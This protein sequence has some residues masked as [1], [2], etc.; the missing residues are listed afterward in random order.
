MATITGGG[1]GSGLDVN[2]IVEKLMEIERKPLATFDAKQNTYQTKLS[3]FSIVKGNLA[4]LQTAAT[5]LATASTFTSKSAT[6]SDA[7]VLS[8]SAS[9]DVAAGSYSISVTQLAKF[10][11]VRSNTDYAATSDTFNTGTLAIS[12]GGGAAVNV[13][14]DGSNNT[15]AGIR[16]AI[17]D[18]VAGV[19]ATI[20]NDGT[21][22]RLILT[23]A[24]SGSA[25][26]INVA[27]TDDG[28][29][30]SNALS[31]L[32]T[33]SLVDVQ[34]AE[35]ALFTINGLAVSRSSNTVTDVV[36]GLTLSLTKGTL[37]SPGTAT[38]TVARNTAVVTSAVE[39]FVKAYNTAVD[40]L[41]S[42]SAYNSATK[43]GGPLNA[44]GTARSIR[45]DLSA[46]TFANVSGVAGS[47]DSLSSLGIS[48]QVNGSLVIDSAVL[49]AAVED[50]SK[51]L[52]S[53]FGQTTVGNEGI[54][55]RFGNALSPFLAGDGL[56]AGRTDGLNSSISYIDNQRIELTSRLS[57]IET[58]YR[59]KYAALDALAASM[60]KT[61]EYLKAQLSSFS[62]NN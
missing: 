42:S 25:G 60:N 53:L 4:S 51:D 57:K 29:G 41:K 45:S 5:S 22:N 20:V 26:A 40:H 8:A 24:T 17:N 23:S 15:L 56:I 52:Q 49:K 48:V 21:T 43:T 16:Q 28:S 13:T 19:N 7:T 62:Q 46:L 27:V 18:A 37:A 59:Q 34:T 2:G 12:V 30:G 50:S 33:V 61:Q 31:Q 32:D 11:A 44:E 38:V 14:I 39:S 36:D 47:V 6:V 58:R 1:I 35:N 9:T 54:A 3:A 10:H 55:V